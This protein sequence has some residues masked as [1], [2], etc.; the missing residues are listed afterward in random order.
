M[1]K[2][3]TSGIILTFLITGTTAFSTTLNFDNVVGLPLDTAWE[4]AIPDG[5]GGLSWNNAGRINPEMAGYNSLWS[6]YAGL[7]NNFDDWVAFNRNANPVTIFSDNSWTWQG[8]TVTS[9]WTDSAALSIH[10]SLGGNTVFDFTAPV[11]LLDPVFIPGIDEQIDTLTVSV[12]NYS[13]DIYGWFGM[14]DFQYE[15][16]SPVPEP[17]TMMLFGAGLITLITTRNQIRKKE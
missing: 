15:Q 1:K 10:G 11:T 12:V 7:Q 2:T 16:S 9:A 5:Y 13:P 17:C 6:G 14:D 8:F 4:Q 3:I